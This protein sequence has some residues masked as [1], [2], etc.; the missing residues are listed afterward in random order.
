VLLVCL[1][2]AISFVAFGFG[3]LNAT[4]EAEDRSIGTEMDSALLA[5]LQ[6][7]RHS[8]FELLAGI[9]ALESSATLTYSNAHQTDELPA[10]A[11]SVDSLG[12]HLARSRTD[13]AGLS[14]RVR[15]L[16]DSIEAARSVDASKLFGLVGGGP[17]PQWIECTDLGVVLQ[18]QE[19]RFDLAALEGDPEAFQRAARR[20]E[21]VVFLVRPS[22]YAAFMHARR[23]TEEAGVGFGFEPVDQNVVLRYGGDS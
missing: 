5:R 9:V 20:A 13:L 7:A 18:P 2:G 14:D 21:Y 22:G 19:L 12:Q 8:L 3:A 1:T 4:A 16:S 15:V 17:P 10:D 6:A 23:L 11:Q